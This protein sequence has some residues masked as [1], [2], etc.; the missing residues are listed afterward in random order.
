MCSSL[1]NDRDPSS[2]NTLKWSLG[3]NC[4]SRRKFVLFMHEACSFQHRH[5][6]CRC[7]AHRPTHWICCHRQCSLRE[8]VIKCST[9]QTEWL[10]HLRRQISFLLKMTTASLSHR[11]AGLI[12]SLK[13]SFRAPEAGHWICTKRREAIEILSLGRQTASHTSLT[14]LVRG[15]EKLSL[16]V[17]CIWTKSSA[18]FCMSHWILHYWTPENSLIE[19]EPNQSH[20]QCLLDSLTRNSS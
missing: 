2:C 20:W 7:H 18:G 3:T 10:L 17:F 14:R 13:A 15:L 5:S 4:R 8:A 16:S 12:D 1:K 6:L 11:S 19:L 9:G